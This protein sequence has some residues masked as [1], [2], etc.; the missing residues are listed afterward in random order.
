MDWPQL[1]S[2]CLR[3]HITIGV[4]LGFLGILL[5][6]LLRKC[7]DLAFN[8][9]TKTTDQGKENYH[10]GLKFSNSYK[11]SMVCSTCLLGVHISMLL[12]LLN[13]QETSCNS[14]VR[15]FSAEV[16]QMISWAI[17]LV[18]VFRIFPSRRYVKFPWIIRAW[19]LCSFMLSI[20]CTSLD[21]NFKITNH[22]HLRLR[23]YADLFALLPSTFLLAISFRGKTGIVF[24][25]F[26]G[27]TD[28]LLHEKSDKDS[29]TKRESP[30]GKATLLQ[31]I[32]FSWLTPLFAVGYKKPLEQDEIPDVYIKDSAGFLSSS[33]DENLNQE[34]L[35]GILKD[36]TII[37][38]THQVEFLPAADIILVMQ[39][40]RIAEAGTFSELLKQNVGFEA[41]V[42]AHSQALE[43]VLTVENPRRTSQDPEPDSESN[44]ESTSNSNCLSHYESDHD[45]SA[46]EKCQLG[47]LVR[48]K[49]EKLDSPGRVAEFDTPA[50]LLEREESFFS[51]LIKEYSMR[52]QSFNSLTN[53]HA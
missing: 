18:A 28:P 25:A 24:N 33:F 46:L 5:L 50:R 51:K 10:I 7:V 37:Y 34:C 35:M 2:L 31:L 47:D 22:G 23:D 41:L 11:A 52:S 14:I 49:D 29:D 1:Q 53:V 4:Q 13:G 27:V 17:T 20:V 38:V 21:I 32:T 9:G 6:H 44:T 36:K 42:G 43:S 30:Y 3:E 40:G 19:W 8:G 15:V 26:N 12:V 48:A 39:N 45:L 16:L